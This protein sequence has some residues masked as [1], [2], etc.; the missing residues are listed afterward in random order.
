[1]NQQERV[2]QHLKD[3]GCITSW[4]A[5]MEYGVTRI[6]AKIFELRK[7]GYKIKTEKRK[8]KNRYGDKVCYGVYILEE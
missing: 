2:L 5:I 1:M 8:S 6:S 3:Y 7:Q 4:Q